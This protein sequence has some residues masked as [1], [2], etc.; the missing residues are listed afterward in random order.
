MEKLEYKPSELVIRQF[1][2]GTEYVAIRQAKEEV[3]YAR[4]LG[5]QD[6]VPYEEREDSKDE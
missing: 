2:D 3:E 6:H 5:V 1:N 4:S